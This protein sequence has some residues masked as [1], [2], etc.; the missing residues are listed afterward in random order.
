VDQPESSVSVESAATCPARRY[1]EVKH[2]GYVPSIKGIGGG[3]YIQIKVCADC[4]TLQ[5][6]NTD[7]TDDQIIEA[8]VE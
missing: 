1:G 5:G 3:D 8:L 2:D 6:F 4:G 7:M